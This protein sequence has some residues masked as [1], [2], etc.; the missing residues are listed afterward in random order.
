MAYNPDILLGRISKVSGFEGAVAIKLE[1]LFI[2]NIPDNIE[3]VFLEIEGRPV[4]FFI[5][6]L[7]YNGGDVLRLQFADYDTVDRVCEFTGSRVFLT[8]HHSV[9]AKKFDINL[10][11]YRVYSGSDNLIGTITDVASVSGQWL[12]TVRSHQQKDI[13]IPLHE[14]LIT[15]INKKRKLIIMD[16]PEGLTEIN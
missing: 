4:P 14:D 3:S 7:Q 2:E 11:G 6:D 10:T 5:S 9:T 8:S 13:L 16:L 15:E 12:L 1:K